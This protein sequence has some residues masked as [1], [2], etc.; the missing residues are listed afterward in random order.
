MNAITSIVLWISA[1]VALFSVIGSVTYLL[2]RR[3]G[4]HTAATSATVALAATLVLSVLVIS[5]WPKWSLSMDGG[6]AASTGKASGTRSIEAQASTGGA[7][8]TQS[9]DT[10]TSTGGVSGTQSCNTQNALSQWW[11]NAT[12]WIWSGGDAAGQQIA[13]QPVWF[14]WIPV[15]LGVGMLFGLLRLGIRLWGVS[16]LRRNSRRIED[17]SLQAEVGGLVADLSGCFKTAS[18]KGTGTFYSGGL[19][20]MSQSPAVLNIEARECSLLRS[21]ATIGWRRPLLLLPAGWR[22]WTDIERRAV[23]A[24]ELA[25]V[26]RRDYFSNFLACVATTIHFYQPLVLW[27]G[28]QL[29]IQQELAAD[30][31]AAAVTGSRQ[32]YL[33]TLAQMA[34]RAD[35]QPLPWA[36]R[37]FLPGTS[38]LVR[39]VKWL[40]A[41]SP[42]VEK[43]LSRSTRWILVAAMMVVALAVAGVRGPSEMGANLAVA[44]EPEANKPEKKDG[45]WNVSSQPKELRTYEYIPA[46]ATAVI[47]VSP[48]ALAKSPG[49]GKLV[50]EIGA[51]QRFEKTFGLPLSQ[52]A[53]MKFV[54]TQLGPHFERTIVQSTK[55]HDWKKDIEKSIPGVVEQHLGN[56]TYLTLDKSSSKPLPSAVMEFGPS[57]YFPDDRTAIGGSEEE[58]KKIVAGGE[59]LMDD[60]MFPG[61]TTAQVG[62]WVDH[63]IIQFYFAGVISSMIR[64]LIDQTKHATFTANL[65]TNP[66]SK[67]EQAVLSLLLD[68]D[69]AEGAKQ[70]ASTLEAAIT[71]GKN[72][73][74]SHLKMV[75]GMVANAPPEAKDK[76]TLALAMGKLA[77]RA[78]EN[79]KVDNGGGTTF[80]MASTN[81]VLPLEELTAMIA[82]VM[83]ANHEAVLR[84]VSMSNLK[85][86]GLANYMFENANKHFL[87][88]AIY[89]GSG[90]PLLS[91][92]VAILPYLE[93]E[94]LY[95]E[96][97]LD[98]PWDSEHNKALIAKMPAVFRDPHEPENSTNA[99]YFMPTGMGTIGGN[100]EG[101]KVQNITDGTSKTIMLVEAKRDIPWTKPEDIEIDPDASKP[102]PKFGGHITGDIFAATFADGHVE[103]LNDSLDPKTLRA[104]FTIA[105]GEYER[106]EVYPTRASPGTIVQ[107][108]KGIQ[109]EL[110]ETTQR[111]A[112]DGTKVSESRSSP[113]DLLPSDIQEARVAADDSGHVIVDIT[114]TAAGAKKMEALS[115]ENQGKTLMIVVDGKAV[116]QPRIQS[117]MSDKLQIS[118]NLS[119]AEAQKIVKQLNDNRDTPNPPRLPPDLQAVPAVK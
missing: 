64:P 31:S 45:T 11:Q 38:M 111:I 52:I 70:V 112:S 14:S 82:P 79:L 44:A 28:R 36:A 26:A 46:D 118:G 3:R 56:S 109:F 54:M 4:P 81:F 12:A 74:A 116:L 80:V 86:L 107:P 96:F 55:P 101:V 1:Q 27:L 13:A 50:D 115:K 71:L 113:T 60:K 85:Q 43:S 68:C 33:E 25:H 8:G 59:K 21:A 58:I 91:W 72:M 69:S 20:K 84:N 65:L 49:L 103:I 10:Q 77:T 92:R 37:A 16:Q 119:E 114:M 104:M 94:A 47:V 41:K 88:P 98:E 18:E 53:D 29:R 22:Q 6:P 24:H 75:E 61:M 108:P 32:T 7:S 9:I 2:L 66:S 35:E 67:E 30:S 57:F 97:H 15:V 95:K 76:I 34:L 48:S 62:V 110:S 78:I 83:A 90:K 100:K 105:G 93:Q 63:Q 5:P 39:R 89:D 73:L 51:M 17:E 42:K 117:K 23:L 106:S 40:K 87:A 99:S 102:L 19:R